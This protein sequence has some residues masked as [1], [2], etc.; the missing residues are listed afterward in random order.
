MYNPLQFFKPVNAR[1]DLAGQ[2]ASQ[3]SEQNRLRDARAKQEQQQQ[4]QRAGAEKYIGLQG[5]MQSGALEGDEEGLRIAQEGMQGGALD[6]L[7][8]KGLF[9][10][11][12]KQQQMEARKYKDELMNDPRVVSLREAQDS[13]YLKA[14]EV[15][16]QAISTTNPT[17]R[18]KLRG[19][20]QKL[21]TTNLEADRQLT[22]FGMDAHDKNRMTSWVKG[23]GGMAQQVGAEDT[24]K[25]KLDIL[26]S[27]KQLK[28]ESVKNIA[29]DRALTSETLKQSKERTSDLKAGKVSEREASALVKELMRQEKLISNAS[30]GDV[31]QDALT[32]GKI[33][34]AMSTAGSNFR[35]AIL[36]DKSGAAIGLQE[37]IQEFAR[38]MPSVTDS[39]EVRAEKARTRAGL[40]KRVIAGA[41]KAYKGG[42]YKSPYKFSSTTSTSDSTSNKGFVWE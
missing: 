18:E 13:S 34:T 23:L 37:E 12:M 3:I 28:D 30:T 39:D 29:M 41:G 38:Y 2:T 17:E 9:D 6:A 32:F 26:K 33:P 42:D 21:L 27:E 7:G 20:Y 8:A 16:S 35:E 40:I 15:L 14:Q 4:M 1:F 11:N 31:W 10:F 19:D 25:A 22:G 5:L 36:R 24:A